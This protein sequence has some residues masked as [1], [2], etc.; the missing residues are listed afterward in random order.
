MELEKLHMALKHEEERCSHLM[1][2]NEAMSQQLESARLSFKKRL[3]SYQNELA[4]KQERIS[5]LEAKLLYS[6]SGGD[7]SELKEGRAKQGGSGHDHLLDIELKENEDLLALSIHSISYNEAA[8]LEDQSST[9]IVVDFFEHE[10][11]TSDVVQGLN[12]RF[13]TSFQFVVAVDHF[14]LSYMNA[15][16]IVLEVNKV[17]GLDYEVV[18]AAE[19]P[20]RQ[21]LSDKASSSALKACDIF[22]TGDRLIGK[23][24]Y[25]MEFQND[26]VRKMGGQ[27]SLQSSLVPTMPEE[28]PAHV[29]TGFEITV[30]G[31]SGLQVPE[32]AD[33]DV[34]PYL[35]Y[36]LLDFAEHE[37]VFGR[38]KDPT[39]N[40]RNV[41]KA[42]WTP[43][44]R[45]ALYHGHLQVRCFHDGPASEEG[46]IGGCSI[47]TK[48]LADGIPIDGAFS[49]RAMTTQ[50]SPRSGAARAKVK[51][52]KVK[53]RIHWFDKLSSSARKDGGGSG[54]PA[55]RVVAE[56]PAPAEPEPEAALVP[57]PPPPREEKPLASL[58]PLTAPAAPAAAARETEEEQRRDEPI[59]RGE[60]L[61]Q[62]A[63]ASSSL[64]AAIAAAERAAAEEHEASRPAIDEL[65]PAEIAD[66][67]GDDGEPARQLQEAAAV[68]EQEQAGA[69]AFDAEGAMGAGASSPPLDFDFD[70]E[71]EIVNESDVSE[72][73]TVDL[74]GSGAGAGPEESAAAAGTASEMQLERELEDAIEK[75]SFVDMTT[76]NMK[77]PDLASNVVVHISKIV[78]SEGIMEEAS[79]GQLCVAFD[80]MTSFVDAKDQCTPMKPK[81]SRVVDFSHTR[82]FCVDE[83]THG[84]MREHLLSLIA[85]GNEVEGS[86]PFCLVAE[87]QDPTADPA[88]QGAESKF[89]DIAY[90]E[91]S[92]MA[93]FKEM[94]DIVEKEYAMITPDGTKVATLHLSVFAVQALEAI[95]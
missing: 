6:E 76:A 68:G 36:R 12:A 54:A 16:N 22:G 87:G 82:E 2:E 52:G 88:S 49:L 32:L 41:I 43:E 7:L 89:Q 85:D 24:F 65:T 57:A 90:C 81:I 73:E 59:V 15:R 67:V 18:G 50:L 53:V 33:A 28:P 26:L 66:L 17:S 39:L 42:E 10:P 95:L 8:R 40:D 14:F 13:D 69:R 91:V 64:Q 72:D 46:L 58:P 92:L 30:E 60:S 71:V 55:P 37:T 35:S 45:E 20:L 9:F 48:D 61:E 80:F 47:S 38:G 34:V 63:A 56:A 5:K 51:A 70:K 29:A 75:S 31:C 23:L 84:E 3:E 78:L 19:I 11:Q 44:L 74:D 21:M 62:E 25:S 86:I 83:R 1:A 77:L 27:K 4:T 79:I 93:I 94:Q